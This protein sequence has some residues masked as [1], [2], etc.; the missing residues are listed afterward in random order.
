MVRPVTSTLSP[1]W[2]VADSTRAATLTASPI[3]ENSS[4]PAPPT[5]PAT[6]GPELSPMPTDSVPVNSSD[7]ASAISRAAVRAR[8]A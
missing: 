4:R 5:L 2:R 3:T 1:V 6:T 7:T 8:S